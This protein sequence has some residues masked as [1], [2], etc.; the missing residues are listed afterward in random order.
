M[1]LLL[2]VFNY[3]TPVHLHEKGMH[4]DLMRVLKKI[5]NDPDEIKY[6]LD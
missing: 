6:R 4:D 3:E 2:T 1:L 5:Y